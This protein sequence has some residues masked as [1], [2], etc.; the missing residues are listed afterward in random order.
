MS[1]NWI[2]AFAGEEPRSGRY[3]AA[4]FFF[5]GAFFAAAVVFLAVVFFAAGVASSG[6]SV[7]VV[8]VAGVTFHLSPGAPGAR[9]RVCSNT[10]KALVKRMIP[11]DRPDNGS[12]IHSLIHSAGF[13]TRHV[14]V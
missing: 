7:F 1:G 13:L 9:T 2:P 6:S 8:F 11:K 3:S 14:A 5:A 12:G 4:T 10:I